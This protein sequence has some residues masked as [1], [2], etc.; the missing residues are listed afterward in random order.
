MKKLREKENTQLLLKYAEKF[1]FNLDECKT[2]NQ[3][4]FKFI[5]NRQRYFWQ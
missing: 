2:L 5:N 1:N 4:I 3:L